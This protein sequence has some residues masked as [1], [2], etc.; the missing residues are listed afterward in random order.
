VERRVKAHLSISVLA[1]HFVHVLRDCGQ[2]RCASRYVRA[3]MPSCRR[4]Q[5]YAGAPALQCAQVPLRQCSDPT[6]LGGWLAAC[7]S[8]DQAVW[9]A[10]Q[11]SGMTLTA[12]AAELGLSVGRVSQLVAR[13]RAVGS[14]AGEGYKLKT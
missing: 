3:A 8:R 11:R 2:T 13:A 1:Y 4:M 9:M 7:D 12:I 5:A 14:G 6:T 10:H